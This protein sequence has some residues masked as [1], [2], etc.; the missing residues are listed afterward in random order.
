MTPHTFTAPDGAWLPPEVIDNLPYIHSLAVLKVLLAI[1]HSAMRPGI[2]KTLLS[3]TDL[4]Q[5]TGMD[6]CQVSRAVKQAR[7]NRLIIRQPA[8]GTFV[9]TIAVHRTDVLLSNRQHRVVKSSTLDDDDLHPILSYPE[10]SSTETVDESSTPL[11]QGI[12]ALGVTHIATVEIL[13]KYETQYIERHLQNAKAAQ[14]GGMARN[15][16]GWLIRSLQEDW[17]APLVPQ[18]KTWYTD[19]ESKHIQR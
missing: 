13:N 2:A 7:A 18:E 9:Y 1:V 15:P 17:P 14:K 8:A 12:R 4:A 5:L 19:E 3:L 11:Y 16:A 10:T 6:R